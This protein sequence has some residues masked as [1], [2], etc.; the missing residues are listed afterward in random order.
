MQERYT[1]ETAVWL[2]KG[3]CTSKQLLFY[4]VTKF[5]QRMYR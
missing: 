3:Y 4:T 5:S 2:T 1:R